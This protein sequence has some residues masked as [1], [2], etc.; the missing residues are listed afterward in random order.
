MHD[1]LYDMG[2]KERANLPKL[3]THLDIF[4]DH[5]LH[6]STEWDMYGGASASVILIANNEP[7]SV[8]AIHLIFYS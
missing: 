7:Q 3:T 2:M 5:C 4:L 6:T 8:V 1:N